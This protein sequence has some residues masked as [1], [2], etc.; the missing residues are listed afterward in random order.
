MQ[1]AISENLAE[2]PVGVDDVVVTHELELRPAKRRNYRREKDA[3]QEL[4]A[5]LDD[6]PA[7]VLPRFVELAMQLTGASSAGLSLYEPEPEP[8][9]FRWHHLR[10]KL[11][12][13][14]GTTT[15]RDHSP[16]GVTLDRNGP[17]LS[18]NPERLYEW[19]AAENITIPEVL[20]VPLH[21]GSDEPLG[22]LWV[23]ADAAGHFRKE[24]AGV[25]TELARFVAIA[26]R[27]IGS[28][29][30][31]RDSLR[32][33]EL[34]AN[35]M[36][37]RVKNVFAVTESIVRLTAG[38][39]ES[40]MDLAE[41]LSRRLGALAEAHAL[42]RGTSLDEDSHVNLDEL[43][44]VIVK[45][46]Q[47]AADSRLVLS[48][49]DVGCGA[50]AASAL[51]LVIHELATNAA[52]YGA[53]TRPSGRVEIDWSRDEDKV[54]LTW[55]ETGGPRVD[56]SPEKDGFGSTLIR[57]TVTRQF[58]GELDEQWLAE[59]FVCKM[60]LSAEKLAR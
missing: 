28:E 57:R 14:E 3:L 18:N 2:P 30:Q 33:Q 20:L 4:V 32:R 56:S 53:L 19:I 27:M 10:G 44:R 43:L 36:G 45:P 29:K 24:D 15:P 48:G 26:L 21:V 25:T 40:S 22:T 13:F 5:Q 7:E 39:A 58:G 34:L 42:A 51:A 50:H 35:E 54:V 23:V 12:T 9:I 60:S 59:G 49:P 46:F 38:R 37:H 55:R 31:L 17:V 11:V 52:K 8:G 6:N 47:D 16:C 1:G 41:S